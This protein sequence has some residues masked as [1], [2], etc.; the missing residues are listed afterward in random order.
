MAAEIMPRSMQTVNILVFLRYGRKLKLK[1]E[2][3]ILRVLLSEEELKARVAEL[4][5]QI[6]ADYEGKNLLLV[7]VLKGSVVFMSD[8]MREIR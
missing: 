3:D 1:M 5:K 8:L 2:N 4:G 7:G 6:S